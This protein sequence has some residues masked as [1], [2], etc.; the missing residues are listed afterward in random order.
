MT[1]SVENVDAAAVPNVNLWI[2]TR[3]DYVGFDN[4]PPEPRADRPLKEK[5]RLTGTTFSQIANT[6][7]PANALR[8]T[9]RDGTVLFFSSTPN[10]N[11][12]VQSCC[13]FSNAY[14][15]APTLSSIQTQNDGSY[16][17][18]LKIGDLAPAGAFGSSAQL[19]WFY[20][21]GPVGDAGSLA[22]TVS[23]AAPPAAPIAT[24]GDEQVGLTWVTPTNVSTPTG[25][26]IRVT[27]TATGA[28]STTD[29]AVSGGTATTITGLTNDV[30]YTFEVAVETAGGIGP[31]STPSEAIPGRPIGVLPT[32]S[33]ATAPLP[34]QT[35]SGDPRLAD[36]RW[37]E[38]E[39]D[40]TTA[41]SW[42]R[43]GT[44][45]PGATDATHTIPAD[46]TAPA[47]F[48]LVVTRTS[49]LSGLS[50]SVASAT[51]PLGDLRLVDLTTNRGPLVP[52]FTRDT[53][54]YEIVVES[55]I[56]TIQFIPTMQAPT[57][58]TVAGSAVSSGSSS[59]NV[60]LEFG[61]NPVTIVTSVSGESREVTVVV[62]R[63]ATTPSVPTSPEAT[64]G[65]ASATV[66]W[67]AG[68]DGGSP[69]TGAAL[70]HS[71]DDGTTWV[72]S[73]TTQCILASNECRVV[74]G[75]SPGTPYVF[76]VRLLNSVG[77]GD[78]SPATSDPVTPTVPPAP[79]VLEAPP[80]VAP[81]L[82]SGPV[83][84]AGAPPRPSPTPTARVGE[85]EVTVVPTP[86]GTTRTQ[87]TTTVSTATILEVGTVALALDVT[88]A[89]EVRTTTGTA[90]E[91]RVARDSVARTSGG[92]LLPGTQVQAWLP[93]S[94]SDARPVVI[95]PVAEDGT[96]T[97]D[98]PFDGRT[99]RQTDG[100]PLPIGRH[101]LQLVGVDAAGEILIIEQTITIEQPAPAP[102][103]DRNAGAPP[104]LSPGASIATNAGVP[105]A[106]TIVP[107]PE[108]RQARVEGTGW[109]MAVDIPSADGRV[110][111]AEG[112][113][114]LIELVEE[115]FAEVS[116]DGF[117][118]GT[119]ADVW[120]FST[121]TL[122]G[123]VTI[124]PDGSFSGLVPV[125]GIATGEHTL[126]LQGVG[127]D[128]YVRAANLGVAVVPRAAD[129][130]AP[131]PEPEPEPEAT[132]EP[133][134]ERPADSVEVVTAAGPEPSGGSPLVW[135][136][137]L[138]AV[139]GSS[140]WWFLIGRRRRDDEA[141]AHQG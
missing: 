138:A 1:T 72:D 20:A 83:L 3:D 77:P 38:G 19:V 31:Y 93:L 101:V 108:V 41:F 60:T 44:P 79:P 6:A 25:F 112:G 65:P 90:P 110:E 69:I 103:P 99:D 132:P 70:Q 140:G 130:P 100:R 105:E 56:S 133:A 51:V 127:R 94:G 26:R 36:W 89:G 58:A 84:T 74:T 141:E 11:I 32:V 126:Q 78:F 71:T 16:A 117:L 102:E 81:P 85:R 43:D 52:V 76:R 116:G 17:L 8:I 5:G 24:P 46:T 124:G 9:S 34:G 10:T 42:E 87:G 128:G 104:T 68:S 86:A 67:T 121:P 30:R 97:G 23:A 73:V 88:G 61:A 12:S 37:L 13:S 40:L 111:P 95:L 136:A 22:S 59:P 107:V 62:R 2:G 120:L 14:D 115:D 18:Y 39:D 134:P 98:L 45:I 129:E 114:A 27:N 50:A 15:V 139:L 57:T 131:Q 109:T 21:G 54:S 63:L 118:P 92:G 106:V 123:T 122:L 28:S 82:P 80:V 137:L 4:N 125:T 96:F 55:S 49:T 113:G 53:T 47:G 35:M 91:V 135:I 33:P 66:T 64:A 7:D 119:R 29:I 75:L 48:R